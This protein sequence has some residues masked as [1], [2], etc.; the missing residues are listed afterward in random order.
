MQMSPKTNNAKNSHSF[1]AIEI[2][3]YLQRDVR[4]TF[5]IDTHTAANHNIPQF[6]LV[7][8]NK[9]LQN[10]DSLLKRIQT[11][12]DDLS[13]AVD[14]TKNGDPDLRSFSSWLRQNYVQESVWFDR[15]LWTSTYLHG[16]WIIV[17]GCR[18]SDL[19]HSDGHNE[20]SDSVYGTTTND[21]VVRAKESN[22][23]KISSHHDPKHTTTLVP[24]PL[25]RSPE[26]LAQAFGVKPSQ[27]N[28]L[29]LGFDWAS[30]PIGPIDHWPQ[31][32]RQLVPYMLNGLQPGTIFWG[33]ERTMIYNEAYI[34][35]I[36]ALHPGA[37]GSSAR[38]LFG[39]SWEDH[40]EP[41]WR[42]VEMHGAE[43]FEN[44]LFHLDRSGFLE[45]AYF[46][47]ALTPLWDA[48]GECCGVDNRGFEV[49]RQVV[50]EARMLS[51]LRISESAASVDSLHSF[52]RGLVDAMAS[53]ASDFP[54]FALYSVR[55]SDLLPNAIN[56]GLS[57]LDDHGL[58]ILRGSVGFAQNQ[59]AIPDTLGADT[60]MGLA[61]A[62]RAV[63]GSSS[64][65][66]FSE[67]DG[68]LSSDLLRECD[69][70]GLKLKC[71][72]IVVCPLLSPS[73]NIIGFLALG[74]NP[75]RPYDDEY[76][77]FV[78]L[79]SRQIE[80]SISPILSLINEKIQSLMN[81]QKSEY[82][83]HLLTMQLEEQTY[84]A[85]R[86]ELRFLRFAEQAPV[87]SACPTHP[88]HIVGHTRLIAAS[89]VCTFWEQMAASNMRIKLGLS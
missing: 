61:P 45:E 57:T 67:G 88:S 13:L 3:E 65:I 35:L 41:K 71:R 28:L 64:P 74:I 42:S 70:P 56:D 49:T 21:I 17:S 20:D 63:L 16:R 86:S 2:T 37:L 4:P 83:Q 60:N 36:K 62:F 32:L 53:N 50:V 69:A 73:R 68:V 5:I 52:W 55:D 29:V 85:R 1:T 38:V 33:I 59:S 66:I 81:A 54:L 80:T 18:Q 23:R 30:T 7:F 15:L 76:E 12:L 19:G 14:T 87:S 82:E 6:R 47:Y 48:D 25:I 46:T 40:L 75:S 77:T 79:L 10:A 84:E 78:R 26:I 9:A 24:K 58:W 43:R 11:V 89:S 51:L 39:D 31:I 34:A 27:H 72:Q 22:D 8:S 44:N